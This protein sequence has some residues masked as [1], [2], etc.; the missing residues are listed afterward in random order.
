MRFPGVY[1]LTDNRETLYHL[2]TRAGG[3]MPNAFPRG[4]VFERRS[5]SES[6]QRLNVPTLIEQTQPIILDSAGLPV[7]ELV[8]SYRPETMSRVIIDVDRML[9][10]NGADGDIILEPGDRIHV[11]PTPS[12]I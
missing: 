10:T 11:P 7:K 5:I 8:F 9:N 1:W 2:L 4:L 12:G 6:L 3:F